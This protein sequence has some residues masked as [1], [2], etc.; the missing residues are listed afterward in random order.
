MLF[1]SIVKGAPEDLFE[2]CDRYEPDDGG[3]PRPFDAAAHAQA[4][5]VFDAMS[6]DGYRLLA[7][8]WRD[9]D[10][11]RSHV[12]AGD[13]ASLVFAGFVAFVD[14]PK[15]D[16]SAAID[17]LKRCGI[18]IKVLTGDNELVTRHVCK[19]LG[20]DAATMLTGAE[21]AALSDDALSVCAEKTTLFCRVT[22][23]QKTRIL[24]ALKQRGH[25]VGFLGDGIN[26]APSLHM[27][28]VG[29]S[30]D[31]AV[32]V[33]KDAADMILLEKDLKVLEQGVRE[34]R[35]TF[36]NI[37]K[38]VMMA[39][40]SNFGNMFSMA[41]ASL[42]L[43]FLPMLPIQILLNN[44]MYDVSE[45]AIPFDDVDPETLA[46]PSHW[47]IGFIRDFMLVL[48][49]VSSLFD[50]L[51]FGLLLWGFGADESLFQTGWFI[52]SLATQVLIV[53]VIRTQGNPLASR[54][55]LLLAATSLLVVAAGV[56]LPF[57]P[58]GRWFGFV[59]PPAGFLAALAGM[60]LCYL[61]LAQLVK[62]WFY[63]RYAWPGT[64][65]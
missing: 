26:D 6:A 64:R 53:F 54:P 25:T 47:D 34:G 16:A 21:V 30:V 35:R 23:S 44:L 51:T 12:D 3:I 55:H 59:Q 29:I 38:Y 45:V 36:G 52:E 42:L 50:F 61:A 14:P 41:G 48:G 37:M 65:R 46:T 19:E 20:I 60:T 2:H 17:A 13:E 39:T 10:G 11:A 28:D 15:A 63:S 5:Q 24:L 32:D 57:T 27:A 9:M 62:R 31:G 22:P 33:A 8:A 58:V 7:V 43:S 4:R 49:P 1:R 40:S 56:V 18:L